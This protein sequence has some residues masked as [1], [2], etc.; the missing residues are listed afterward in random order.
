[1]PK[2]KTSL[3]HSPLFHTA[4][5]TLNLTFKLHIR[6]FNDF[7]PLSFAQSGYPTTINIF[8][9]TRASHSPPS[10]RPKLIL[11]NE[12][13]RSPAKKKFYSQPRE[14]VTRA[15]TSTG[16]KWKLHSILECI[17]PRSLS[18]FA[19][20]LGST[21]NPAKTLSLIHPRRRPGK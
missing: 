15:C 6:H 17:R 4:N 14:K 12:I 2:L 10:H 19:S 1:M 5:L 13:S 8:S 16:E 20:L 3:L 9:K 7:S 21:P 11:S 18:V